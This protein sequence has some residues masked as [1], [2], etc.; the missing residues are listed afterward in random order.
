[1]FLVDTNVLVY[2]A[3]EDSPE[4][5]RC[6]DLVET[7]RRRAEPWYLTWG[8]I[9]EFCRVVTHRRVMERPWTAVGAL[10]YVTA[11]LASPGLVVLRETDRHAEV[12]A[13]LPGEVPQL[14]GNLF[15]D[16]H[17]AALMREHGISV[18][19]TRD[20]DFHRFPWIDVRDPLVA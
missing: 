11:L 15:H 9:Y 3:H 18:I 8:I 12:L 14:D 17:T 4:H 20:T 6:R 13:D 1:M 19:Y 5:E 16:A 2:A 10:A 7:W